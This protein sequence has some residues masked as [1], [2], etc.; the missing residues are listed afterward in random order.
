VDRTQYELERLLGINYYTLNAVEIKSLKPRQT[1]EEFIVEEID[2]NNIAVT[3]YVTATR[4]L[5]SKPVNG[6]YAAYVLCKR[7]IST[8]KALQILRR[9]LHVP[10]HYVT[11]AGLKDA[12]ALTCQLVHVNITHKNY[13]PGI[14]WDDNVKAFLIGFSN[15]P[16]SRGD[17]WGNKFT[18]I[19][20][21]GQ[22][23]LSKL[24]N[25]YNVLKKEN[26]L[27]AYYGYQ[28]FGTRR[29]ITHIIGKYIVKREWCSTLKS[30]INIPF[31]TENERI[32]RWRLYAWSLRKDSKPPSR[33][34][35]EER[36]YSV[37]RE[38]RESY[39]FNILVRS[40][41]RILFKLFL[42]AYQ[43]Y[44]FNYIL[45]LKIEDQT[46]NSLDINDN[47][48]VPG[49]K[50]GRCDRH[51]RYALENENVTSKDFYVKELKMKTF[52]YKRQTK[53]YI[54]D[55][56]IRVLEASNNIAR[57]L[58]SFRLRKGMYATMVLRELTRANPLVLT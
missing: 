21:L 10:E 42:S 22:D 55:P 48:I 11:I 40:I 27:P 29:P 32:V 19:L 46:Y 43:S 45:S 57:V 30:I 53:M 12:N 4:R 13:I 31:T 9:K 35:I 52:S 17:L 44:L 39:C 36:I 34:D 1:P 5:Q 23:E 56:Q 54:Y 47:I 18:I 16:L 51:C 50:L 7:G 2:R 14:I 24:L 26:M 41:P 3:E 38:E 6:I 49:Y 8:L 58:L 28:R 33:L 37:L 25:N 15:K 20:I